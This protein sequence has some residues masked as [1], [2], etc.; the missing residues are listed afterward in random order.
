[1]KLTLVPDF[2]PPFE[3]CFQFVLRDVWK[4]NFWRRFWTQIKNWCSD[5]WLDLHSTEK[6][7]FSIKL[8]DMLDLWPDFKKRT[9]LLRK[10]HEGSSRWLTATAFPLIRERLGPIVI[11]KENFRVSCSICIIPGASTLSRY[12]QRVSIPIAMIVNDSDWGI[13]KRQQGLWKE[14]N[15][16]TTN[17]W[18]RW[19]NQ[20]V[21]VRENRARNVWI[22]SQWRTPSTFSL[23]DKLRQTIIAV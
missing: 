6:S 11:V 20:V 9:C 17:K 1:M 18:L 15:S 16:K 8:Q 2:F 19:K 13:L 22:R 7:D 5:G 10:E 4:R 21:Q 12:R 3:R 14:S 23:V